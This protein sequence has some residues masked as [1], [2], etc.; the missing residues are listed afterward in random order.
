MTIREYIKRFTEFIKNIE[1]HEKWVKD[2]ATE[3]KNPQFTTSLKNKVKQRDNYECQECGIKARQLRQMHSYLTIHH[4]NFNHN[5]CKME[6]LITLCPLCH[7][8]TNFIKTS[9]I[10]YYMEKMEIT[11]KKEVKK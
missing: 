3:T 10:K 6:N 1:L 5:D 4:I 9:W 8:K 11:N 2:L 7:A